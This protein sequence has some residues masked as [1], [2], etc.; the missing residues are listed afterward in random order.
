[1]GLDEPGAGGRGRWPDCGP[2]QGYSPPGSS[3]S[4]GQ[5][6][7]SLDACAGWTSPALVGEDGGLPVM[8]AAGWTEAQKKLSGFDLS[9]TG[10]GELELKDIM[11]E[12][13]AGL[14]DPDDTP[15]AP[16]HQVSQAALS[17]NYPLF[18]QQSYLMCSRRFWTRAIPDLPGS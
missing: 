17:I 5:H 9:L 4:P 2:R 8:V 11:A 18:V 12:R 13:T 16:E 1:M 14:T 10:F 15:A 6:F 7:P 3:A